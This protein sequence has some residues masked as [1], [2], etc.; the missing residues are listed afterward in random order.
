MDVAG[1]VHLAVGLIKDQ[2]TMVFNKTHSV[3]PLYNR[4]CKK[5]GFHENLF[6]LRPKMIHSHRPKTGV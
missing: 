5:V 3:T 1:G 4:G 2:T 6:N